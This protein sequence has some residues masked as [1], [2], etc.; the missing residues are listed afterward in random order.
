MKIGKRTLQSL[1][2]ASMLMLYPALGRAETDGGQATT[3]SA[4]AVPVAEVERIMA[5]QERRI[6]Q[7]E[8]TLRGVQERLD[9]GET[10]SARVRSDATGDR[11]GSE[12]TVDRDYVD[13]RIEDFENSPTSRFLISGYGTVGLV[14]D[15][16]TAFGVSF[17]PGFHFRMTDKLH[18]NAELE[19][20]F[21]AD[22]KRKQ[23]FEIDLE[24]AQFD[25]L[26]TD[27]LVISGGR[28]LTPFNTFGTRLH[29]TWI[30]KL[31]S[32][33]PIYGGHGHGSGGFIPVM[34]TIGAMVS[35]GKALWSDDAKINYAL[36]V[37]NGPTSE[38][39][40]DDPTDEDELLDL[41]FNNTPDLE[42][43]VMVG[44]RL[45][46]LPIRNLEL[47]VS[48]ATSDP[49]DVRFHLIGVDAWY[50]YEG[51]ELR[52]EFAYLERDE[53]S[54]DANVQGYWLQAAYRL[55][56]IFPE[57][58]GLHGIANR[59][60]PVVRF[61]QVSKFSEKN[62]DQLVIG[63]NYWLFESAPLKVS[64]EFNNGA[65]ADNRVLVNF[66]YGF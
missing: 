6:E 63:L 22:K 31:S 27:W 21:E 66:A 16:I 59:L 58:N 47:G 8:S 35:G 61:G 11:D 15:G 18:L 45:G 2:L 43:G 29:P 48:Y 38:D 3:D 65:V 39:G 9:N 5:E 1:V 51:L 23:E 41:E 50:N 13:E 10:G 44:G 30:N 33:P 28:F 46:F 54:V 26:A 49:D 62:R 12:T 20:E 34:K 64:Y 60:E 25:Y 37:G 56:R 24:F 42:D 53:G 19:M 36:F 55:N 7:L 52:G 17:N 40:V 14:D 32:A 57:R 4:R